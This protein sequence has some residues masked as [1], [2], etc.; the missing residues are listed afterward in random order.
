VCSVTL[1]NLLFVPVLLATLVLSEISHL[2]A[3]INIFCILEQA[4]GD[5]ID[6]LEVFYSETRYGVGLHRRCSHPLFRPP[7]GWSLRSTSGQRDGFVRGP[8]GYFLTV[9]F[10]A[11]HST[12]TQESSAG[13][14]SWRFLAP[15]YTGVFFIL[16]PTHLW[17][18]ACPS[19]KENPQEPPW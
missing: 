14:L 11:I 15:L 16:D 2:S 10:S 9:V 7:C 3:L 4:L 5:D 19:A 12:S 1:Q 8:W 6:L 18:M 13:T 17:T